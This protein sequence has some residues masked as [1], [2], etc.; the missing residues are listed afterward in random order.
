[1]CEGETEVRYFSAIGAE[2]RFN[3]KIITAICAGSRTDP[4]QLVETAV[5]RLAHEEYERVY[6][7]FDR[8]EHGRFAEAIALADRY[9]GQFETSDGDK[10]LM[11]AIPSNPSFELWLLLH[12]QRIHADHP[13]H[14]DDAERK[15]KE[16][17]SSFRKGYAN[18]YPATKQHMQKALERSQ[19]LECNASL[20]ENPYTAVGELVRFLQKADVPGESF[21]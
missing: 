12:Y 21:S 2:C 3:D 16:Y 15:V 19:M 10:V 13:I 4:K 6:C 18:I 11:K 7:V 1:M 17:L 5:S 8:D 9:N 20:F 14:R